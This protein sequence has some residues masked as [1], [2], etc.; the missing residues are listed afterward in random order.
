V[1]FSHDC[2]SSCIAAAHDEAAARQTL[3]NTWQVLSILHGP[4]WRFSVMIS[5]PK[6]KTKEKESK[7]N[8]VLLSV[9]WF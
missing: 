4:L 6:Q 9:L 8:F 2:P 1:R 5:Q 7:I 3:R